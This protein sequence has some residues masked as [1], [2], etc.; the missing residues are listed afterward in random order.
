MIPQIAHRWTQLGDALSDE[1]RR[2]R[3][4]PNR[5]TYKQGDKKEERPRSRDR[6]ALLDLVV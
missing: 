4:R 2:R 3:R 6:E 1:Q 5:S